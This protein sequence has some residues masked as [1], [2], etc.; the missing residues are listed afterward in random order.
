MQWLLKK[1]F[2]SSASYAVAVRSKGCWWSNEYM[3]V[4]LLPSHLGYIW[5]RLDLKPTGKV[6]Q[7]G[8]I[9]AYS[10]LNRVSGYEI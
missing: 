8:P 5:F 1:R 9:P 2:D 3:Q 4:K 7:A 6:Q 10:I